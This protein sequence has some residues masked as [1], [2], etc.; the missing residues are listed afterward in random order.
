MAV[1]LGIQQSFARAQRA[2][3]EVA[4]WELDDNTIRQLCHAT[5]AQ[6]TAGRDERATA[7][8]FAQADGDL[9]LQIDAGK[10]NTVDGWRDVKAAVFA[11]RERGKPTTAEEWDERDLPRPSVRSVLAA[12]EEA[13]PF[14][15]RL[16]G[17]A[18]RL[19]LTD[20]QAFSVLGDVVG[21]MNVG[22]LHDRDPLPLNVP[23]LTATVFGAAVRSKPRPA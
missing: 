14:G 16:A 15:E 10:V 17:E 21:L 5:A 22:R 4:G 6:A 11:K 12:V 2:L 1:F 19:G 8:A 20:P 23:R 13:A 9:E 7:E 3:E 18:R